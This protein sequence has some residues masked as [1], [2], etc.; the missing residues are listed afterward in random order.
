M[1][2]TDLNQFKLIALALMRIAVQLLRVMRRIRKQSTM[3]GGEGMKGR[4]E[5]LFHL[6]DFTLCDLFSEL[7]VL[8]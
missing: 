8:G 6:C 4:R 7:P 5:N 3:V 1:S 2:S